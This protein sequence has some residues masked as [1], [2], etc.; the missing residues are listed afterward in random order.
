MWLEDE[1]KEEEKGFA[2]QNLLKKSRIYVRL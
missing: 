2:Q 1:E